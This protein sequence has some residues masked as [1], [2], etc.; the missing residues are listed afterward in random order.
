MTTLDNLFKLQLQQSEK[1]I[2]YSIAINKKQDKTTKLIILL[3]LK[4]EIPEKHQYIFNGDFEELELVFKE[5]V[6][7]REKLKKYKNK[8]KY[9][10]LLVLNDV[11]KLKHLTKEQV[12][13]LSGIILNHRY[14]NLNIFI[15]YT[16][17]KKVRPL[18][19]CVFQFNE[20]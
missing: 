8:Q 17:Y 2:L 18:F 9:E 13:L 3:E 16:N 1:T 4:K 19:K 7:N 6:S 15:T 5:I 14:L 12:N 10:F 11:D 20:D